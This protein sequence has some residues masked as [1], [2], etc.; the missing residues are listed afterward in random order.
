ML[1]ELRDGNVHANLGLACVVS[2]R[3][4]L[5]EQVEHLCGP[6]HSL[7][8]RGSASGA[9]HDFLH[10]EAVAGVRASIDDVHPGHGQDDLLVVATP[11]RIS[12]RAPS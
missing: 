6:A 5:H 8:E 7:L 12:T 9:D 1:D 11:L 3:D 2:P 4:H 10:D